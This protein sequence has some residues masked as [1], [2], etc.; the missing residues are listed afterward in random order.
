MNFDDD[1]FD[2]ALGLPKPVVVPTHTIEQLPDIVPEQNVEIKTFVQN[3][4]E[5]ARDQMRELISQG[6]QLF[7]ESVNVAK[8]DNNADSFS[9]A[10]TIMKTLIDANKELVKLSESHAKVTDNK[11]REIQ[12]EKEDSE[13]TNVTNNNLIIN[14]S[15]LQELIGNMVNGTKVQHSEE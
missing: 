7:A 10:A 3:D 6:T 9:S 4:Y 11:K 14:T 13:P 12:R 1:P 2:K 5:F 8:Q 15:D